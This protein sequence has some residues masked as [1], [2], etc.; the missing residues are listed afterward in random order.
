LID[1]NAL[2]SKESEKLLNYVNKIVGQQENARDIVQDTFLACY[3]HLDSIDTNFILPWL[4]RT[5]HNKAINFIKK[6]GR[7]IYGEIPEQPHYDGVEEEIRQEKVKRYIQACFAKLKPKHAMVLDLQYYQKKSY[8][9]I[10]EITGMTIAAIE[11]HLV[12]AKKE[13]RK[14]LQAFRDKGVI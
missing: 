8:K 10:S 13:C 2:V 5:A 12:R 9:E 14:I 11:S 4:Y 1:W 7:F 3:R 6:H